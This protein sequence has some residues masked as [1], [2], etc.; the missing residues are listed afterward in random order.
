MVSNAQLG[1]ELL[2]VDDLDIAVIA[3]EDLEASRP[4]FLSDPQFDCLDTD[5]REAQEQLLQELMT[6]EG[7]ERAGGY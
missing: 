5:G 2:V 6:S 3:E 7:N 4:P 1:S